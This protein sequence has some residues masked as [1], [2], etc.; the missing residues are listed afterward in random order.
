MLNFF[1]LF[2]AGVVGGFLGGLLGIGGGIIYIVV[3]PVA[4]SALGVP[5][6][7]L[8]QYTIANSVFASFFSSLSADYYLI[9]NNNF[10][11]KEV[12]LIGLFGICT[13]LLVLHFVVNTTW[14]SKD[15]FNLV[16]V[17]LLIYM[18]LKTLL[19]VNKDV[20]EEKK[21]KRGLKLGLA[22]VASGAVSALS[23]LGGGVVLIPILHSF[24]KMDIKKTSS[25]S[26]GVIGVTSLTMTVFNM[27]ETPSEAFHYYSV[28]Y[29]IFPISLSLAAGVVLA[30]PLGI[31][32][33]KSA[34]PQMISYLFSFFLAL[35]ILRKIIE[36]AAYSV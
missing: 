30:S 33:S 27:C 15:V 9:K 32:A 13:S 35:I 16:I 21:K 25:V 24:F 23:G 18:L 12:L 34:T 3:I 14:Y 31:R 11:F 10:Y 17:V 29:I 26:L 20:L 22:G 4:L 2:L 8:V 7:E 28:G 1:F 36:L 5:R 19:N 6:E